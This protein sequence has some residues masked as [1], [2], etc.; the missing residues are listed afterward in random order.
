M[1][2]EVITSFEESGMVSGLAFDNSG[3]ATGAM[4][5]DAAAYNNDSE[6]ASYN[7]V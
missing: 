4:G 7:F 3:K 5:I 2:Y 1:L 6:F